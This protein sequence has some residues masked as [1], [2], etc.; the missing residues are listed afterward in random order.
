MIEGKRLRPK[1]MAMEVENMAKL[2]TLRRIRWKAMS[3]RMRC[4]YM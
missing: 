4:R 3:G 2:G 1:R